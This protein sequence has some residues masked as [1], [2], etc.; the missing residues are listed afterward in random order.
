LCPAHLLESMAAACTVGEG[1][2][3]KNDANVVHFVFSK[4]KKII[5]MY[6]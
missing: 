1:S 5:I 3:K 4:K 6:V 2:K